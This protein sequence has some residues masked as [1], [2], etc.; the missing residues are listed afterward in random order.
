MNSTIHQNGQYLSCHFGNNAPELDPARTVVRQKMA[1][2]QAETVT[3][4]YLE[5]NEYS[6]TQHYNYQHRASKM[7]GKYKEHTFNNYLKNPLM[8]ILTIIG[9]TVTAGL[10]IAGY[11]AFQTHREV[12]S[13]LNEKI[14][15]M[16]DSDVWDAELK[17]SLSTG[18]M[19]TS[20][21]ILLVVGGVASIYHAS[22]L[23]KARKL[24]LDFKQ[25]KQA[26][27][28]FEKHLLQ[29][30]PPKD[31]ASRRVAQC[32]ENSIRKSAEQ[33]SSRIY[34]LYNSDPDAKAHFNTLYGSKDSLPHSTT[35]EKLFTYSAYLSIQANPA[36]HNP[37]GSTQI[38]HLDFLKEVYTLLQSANQIGDLFQFIKEDP[39]S[40]VAQSFD[41]DTS[42]QT[43]KIRV[44]VENRCE[45]LTDLLSQEIELDRHIKLA[46]SAWVTTKLAQGEEQQKA[47]DL[48]TL[49][50]QLKTQKEKI[51]S[52][53]NQDDEALFKNDTLLT[54]LNDEFSTLVSYLNV[55]LEKNQLNQDVEQSINLAKQA[56]QNQP[57]SQ[58]A[59]QTV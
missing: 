46:Q 52:A 39:Q 56:K 17:L 20:T 5:T 23:T 47:K 54:N 58:N 32:L 50:E 42:W 29:T 6:N 8:Y 7:E 4:N 33:I 2:N 40:P 11:N 24:Y 21:L 18:T 36:K 27:E 3:N 51:K 26:L 37:N 38:T 34:N 30:T 1:L 43:E 10:G 13:Q 14:Q 41:R 44:Q 35:I 31:E 48:K 57:I 15:K 55:V 28:D 16:S 19:G 53:L 45:K 9:A 22:V 12:S 49:L 25:S 59:S